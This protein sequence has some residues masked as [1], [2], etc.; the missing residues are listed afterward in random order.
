MTY[1]LIKEQC[2]LFF[3]EKD[4]VAASNPDLHFNRAMVCVELPFLTV[5]Q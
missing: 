4:P 5:S 2:N 1:L 3:K